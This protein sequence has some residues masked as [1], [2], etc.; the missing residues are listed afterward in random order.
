MDQAIEKIESSNG[1]AAEVPGE[2]QYVLESLKTASKTLKENAQ[3][4]WMQLKVFVL[5][6]LSRVIK[7]F[8]NAAE[9]VAASAAR[10]AIHDWLKTA[11]SKALDWWAS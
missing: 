6:P 1:Y 3:I 4:Y 11:F 9:G 2:R 10:D 8:G 5:E 7:R